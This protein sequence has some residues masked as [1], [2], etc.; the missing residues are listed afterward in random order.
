MAVS[1]YAEVTGD[2]R[3][4]QAVDRTLPFLRFFAFPD[5]TTSVVGDCRQRY[6]HRPQ[7]LVPPALL[8][9]RDGIALCLQRV[10]TFRRN[11]RDETL[12]DNAGLGLAFFASFAHRLF[13]SEDLETP[14]EIGAAENDSPPVAV[15]VS[16]IESSTWQCY[17]SG[18][19]APETPNRFHLDAQNFVEAWHRESG[20]L[21]GGGNSKYMPRFSTLRRTNSG[22]AYIPDETLLARADSTSAV[23]TYRFGGDVIA[24]EIGVD[25]EKLVVSFHV[26]SRQGD[27]VYEACLT[28]P[29]RPGDILAVDSGA[30]FSVAP[31]RSLLHRF[32]V[33]ARRMLW[34]GR[35]FV[36]PASAHLEY[37]II[38]H[39][40]YRQDSLPEPSEYVARLAW[41]PTRAGSAVVIR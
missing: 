9:Y 22:R 13:A 18:Q 24:I 33:Q 2:S 27:A 20:Y 1:L 12:T 17:I 38:P 29:V 41:P 10:R 36:V 35:E 34:R 37:P 28:L 19:L 23:W 32:S 31:N 26:E 30:D 40:P 14:S 6:S 11:L 3:A 15:P 25:D 4:R 21:V 7:L 8:R 5:G 39:N 16:R